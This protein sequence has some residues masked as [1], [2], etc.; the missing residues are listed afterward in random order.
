MS[1]AMLRFLTCSVLLFPLVLAGCVVEP[2]RY[3]S[4]SHDDDYDDSRWHRSTVV[5]EDP[6]PAPH[7]NHDGAEHHNGD[8]YYNR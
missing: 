4:R 3:Y 8:Y 7:Y 5:Y 1:V 2:A 6:A